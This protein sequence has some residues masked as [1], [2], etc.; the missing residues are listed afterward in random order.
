MKSATRP[1]ARWNTFAGAR[2]GVAGVFAG[3]LLAF[4]A[5]L[6]V[7]LL[8]RWSQPFWLSLTSALIN[9]IP[10]AVLAG[11]VI[12]I[13]RTRVVGIQPWRQAVAHLGLALAFC[14]IWY[15]AVIILNGMRGGSLLEGFQVNPFGSIALTWQMF[16]GFALYAVVGV[17]AYALY[18]RTELGRLRAELERKPDTQ[19]AASPPGKV[20]VRGADGLISLDLDEVL[21]VRAAGD[22]A[23]IVTRT[24]HHETRRTLAALTETFAE[25]RFLRAH[26]SLLVNRDAI[27][28]AEPAG[29]G[30]LTLHFP[31]GESVITSRAGARLLREAAL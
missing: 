9:T 19:P 3:A 30:R 31:A 4:F 23:V 17:G 26:R 22:G 25:G 5:Y 16:Q 28:S 29:D 10:A 7:F 6:A 20:M 11:G 15:L 21:Y 18:Y 2:P 8:T 13:I 14:Y 24:K 27:L 12:A 1:I